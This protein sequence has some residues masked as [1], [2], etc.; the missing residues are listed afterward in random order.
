MLT[1]GQ[2]THWYGRDVGNHWACS[3]F[4]SCKEKILSQWMGHVLGEVSA[5]D[6]IIHFGYHSKEMWILIKG[7]G[8]GGG[9]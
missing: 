4:S 2:L 8:G 5:H 6:H 9:Y 3:G 1:N 7:M